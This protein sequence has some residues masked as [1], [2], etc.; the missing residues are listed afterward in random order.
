MTLS[1]GNQ[2]VYSGGWSLRSRAAARL[3]VIVTPNVYP[4][5]GDTSIFA[6]PEPL[7]FEG[8]P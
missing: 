6:L 2:E 1:V 3:A 4:Y 5:P 8:A 7:D